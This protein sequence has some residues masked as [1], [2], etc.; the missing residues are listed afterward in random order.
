MN[1]FRLAAW[2]TLLLDGYLLLALVATSRM[3]VEYHRWL[4]PFGYDFADSIPRIAFVVLAGW[5]GFL[6]LG[7]LC[8]GSKKTQPEK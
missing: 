6:A 4:P 7:C 5:T 3:K 2:L 8:S 1:I